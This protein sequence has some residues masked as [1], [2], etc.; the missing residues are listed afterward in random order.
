MSLTRAGLAAA[1]VALLSACGASASHRTRH[2]QIRV[3]ATGRI[4]PLQIN[5]S[6]R[7]AVIAF[8]GRPT[9]ENRSRERAGAPGVDAL[10]YGCRA[11]RGDLDPVAGCN[12]IF[13]IDLRSSKLAVFR[14]TDSRYVGPHGVHVGTRT[15]VAE[16]A[17][18]EKAVGGCTSSLRVDTKRTFLALVFQGGRVGELIVHSVKLNPGVIDCID[19]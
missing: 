14:A 15:A 3:T 16:R 19:S 2:D 9:S 7:A 5:R 10:F 1:V 13:W 18:H 12:A 11:P 17:F 4:G 8:A 6:S